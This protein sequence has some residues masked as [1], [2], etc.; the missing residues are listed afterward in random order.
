MRYLIF[1]LISIENR[2]IIEK[3]WKRPTVGN[4]TYS[5][6]KFQNKENTFIGKPRQK[7]GRWR[8]SYSMPQKARTE[9]S[10]FLKLI[11]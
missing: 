6:A 8:Q 9:A 7:F 3:K 5:H 11:L 4:S 1:Q 2:P 10:L